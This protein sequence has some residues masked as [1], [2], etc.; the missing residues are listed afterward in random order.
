LTAECSL[1]CKFYPPLLA[2]YRTTTLVPKFTI[3]IVPLP[4]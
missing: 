4:P 3:R 2:L 1:V